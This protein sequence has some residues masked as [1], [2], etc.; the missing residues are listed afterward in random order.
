VRHKLFP[1]LPTRTDVRAKK[2]GLPPL[3]DLALRV[4]NPV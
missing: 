2:K 1:R 3:F 4:P